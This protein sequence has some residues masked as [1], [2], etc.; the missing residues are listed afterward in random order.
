M[1][2]LILMDLDL[3][4][5]DGA[6]GEGSGSGEGTGAAAPTQAATRGEAPVVY[7]K[8]SAPETNAVD[9]Q[10]QA[11]PAT[12]VADNAQSDKRA[13]F[14]D[15]I[16]GEYKDEYTEATQQIINRRF[17]ETKQLESQ[18]QAFQPIM[19]MLSQR[20][21][22]N[23]GDPEKLRQAIEDD[24][25][26]WEQLAE[27]AGMTVDQYK[28]YQRLERENAELRR[29]RDAQ[30]NQAMAQQKMQEWY[31]QADEVKNIYPGFDLELEAANP[32]F[33]A[34][35]QSGVPVQHAYEVLHLDDI[36]QATAQVAAQRTQQNVV[37]NIRAKGNRPAENGAKATSAFTVKDDVSKLSKRDR[38]EI[39][40][41]VERGEKI[42]F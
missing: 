24:D 27:D 14:Q 35:L 3:T 11:E 5:F 9:T 31:Q 23:D 42:V 38:A 10:P 33:L 18:V 20:Y 4:L 25:G 32:Q 30:R 29:Y 1:K 40:K 19:D 16:K 39:A 34:L 2:K 37:N 28:E 6:G 21:G 17:K 36:R 22:V 41:R 15:L 26:Y 8:Q 12:Q 7:G 13:A